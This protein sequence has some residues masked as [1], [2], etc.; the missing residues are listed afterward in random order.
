V[1]AVAPPLYAVIDRR[2]D[3]RRRI[4]SAHSDPHDARRAADLLRW[5]GDPVELGLV[6]AIET[7]DAVHER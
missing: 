7:H 2:R 3:G 1:N 6:T 5:A 4:V